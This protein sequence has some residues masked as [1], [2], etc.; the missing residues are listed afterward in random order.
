[1]A[2]PRGLFMILTI[3]QIEAIRDKAA[4][5]MIEGKTIMEYSDSG[6]TVSKQWPITVDLV[7]LECRFALQMKQPDI[8]G[9]WSR[10][11]VGNM[12]NNFRGL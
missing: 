8:Y 2:G 11:R 12:L 10:V 5:Q 6:T 7:L 9:E 3:P 1:M 4:L